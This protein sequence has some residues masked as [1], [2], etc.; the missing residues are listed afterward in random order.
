MTRTITKSE[1]AD[2]APANRRI[3][4]RTFGC[5]MNDYD[6]ERMYRLMERE[7]WSRTGTPDDADLIV[8]N[9]CSVRE[10]PEHKAMTEIGMM[11]RHRQGRGALVALAGCVAQ[12][13]GER[14]LKRIPDLDLV[15][16][17]HA[18]DR[19]PGLVEEAGARRVAATDWDD[20]HLFAFDNISPAGDAHAG[21]SWKGTRAGG[22]VPIMRGCDKRCTFC[23]VPETRGRE[24]SRPIDDVVREVRDLVAAGVKDVTLLGQIVNRYGRGIARRPIFHELLDAIDA[25][26]GLSRIRFTSSHPVYV[27]PELVER[28]ASMRKLA[29]HIHLPVQS[30]SNRVLQIMRRGHAIEL[31]EERV[32]MLRNARPGLSVTTDLIVG[33]PGETGDDF[34]ATLDLIRRVEFDHLFAFKYSPRPNTPAAAIDDTVDEAEKARRLDAVHAMAAPGIARKMSAFVGRTVEILVE[35]HDTDRP[36]R[37]LGRTS[38]NRA[39]HVDAPG[40]KIGDFLKVSIERAMANSLAGVIDNS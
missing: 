3:F 22:F 30:G 8:I 20:E 27:T 17:T 18:I 2:I 34:E 7:G 13:H 32:A 38:C 14:M 28:F 26:D 39:V 12:Q 40:A 23:I 6:S 36:G 33:Y 29:S 31:F 15:L 19:L 10:K 35:G 1:P 25:I 11:R 21:V 37:V 9:T 4:V 24:M 16:G 5:Q